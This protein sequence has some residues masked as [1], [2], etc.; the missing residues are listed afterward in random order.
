MSLS[1]TAARPQVRFCT[2]I[3]Q[4][5]IATGLIAALWAT[6]G[7]AAVEGWVFT[8]S[9]LAKTPGKVYC[10]NRTCHRVKT[11]A[12]T[13]RDVGRRQSVVASFYDDCR[14]DRYNPC[15]LTSSG[16][17]FRPHAPDNAASPIYPDGTKLLVRNP[18]NG[19]VLIVRINNAGPYWRKRTLD[20]SRAAAEELGFRRRGIARLQVKVLTAPSRS[21]AR[22]RRN[23]TYAP[24]PGYIGRHGTIDGAFRV[25]S[26]MITA[27]ELARRAYA[28]LEPGPQ[29]LREALAASPLGWLDRSEMRRVER[30][31]RRARVRQ[32]RRTPGAGAIGSTPPPLPVAKPGSQRQPARQLLASLG[33]SYPAIKQ[34][35]T[36]VRQRRLRKKTRRAKA[37]QNL[38]TVK[39]SRA[40]SR[41]RLRSRRTAGSQRKRIRSAKLRP[42]VQ[43]RKSTA[44]R[45]ARRAKQSKQRP[46][47]PAI[48][49]RKD[50]RQNSRRR[51]P[52]VR[53]VRS[54]SSTRRTARHDAKRR[55]YVRQVR[56]ETPVRGQQQRKRRASAL[57]ARTS[58]KAASSSRARPALG[59]QARRDRQR[60]Y[61]RRLTTD[62]S[63]TGQ[64]RRTSNTRRVA[65]TTK[66]KTSRRP[67]KRADRSR[68]LRS[69]RTVK[70]A[71]GVRGRSR[72]P[73]K[74]R[75]TSRPAPRAARPGRRAAVRRGSRG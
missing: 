71:S 50:L 66:A 10:F 27:P 39:R 2:R 41:T 74:L 53:T 20:L 38:R 4:R 54:T 30:R 1:F 16:E 46:A 35:G 24:V 18:A 60:R 45:H 14:R 59:K 5:R 36:S 25:A 42:R 29:T 56:K 70:R 47:S 51:V 55:R 44:V 26:L 13:R 31:L 3:G 65:A 68:Q 57:A 63:K 72:R 17:R 32:A 6:L 33:Q 22:Y 73:L 8:G 58:R 64:R 75:G 23:R 34:S 62:K 12:E 49:S 9:A 37:K 21:E 28:S 48:R 69:K 43:R 52:T 7:F 40:N 67:T 19:K 11:I 15:G 61:V